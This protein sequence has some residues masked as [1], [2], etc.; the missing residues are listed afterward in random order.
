[1]VSRWSLWS[2]RDSTSQYSPLNPRSDPPLLSV[3]FILSA[4]PAPLNHKMLSD[5]ISSALSFLQRIRANEEKEIL[6]EAEGELVSVEER[7]A[8]LENQLKHGMLDSTDAAIKINMCLEVGRTYPYPRAHRTLS[9]ATSRANH[10]VSKSSKAR[11]QLSHKVSCPKPHIPNPRAGNGRGFPEHTLNA[12]T[13]TLI[14]ETRH[15]RGSR[16]TSHTL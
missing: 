12:E 7:A 14:L 11:D 13:H 9:S 8:R 16:T 6:N 1:M 10:K 15:G 5:H 2:P 3:I 4:I